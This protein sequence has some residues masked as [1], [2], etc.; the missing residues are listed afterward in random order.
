MTRIELSD[1]CKGWLAIGL[2]Y[3]GTAL[4]IAGFIGFTLYDYENTPK[5]PPPPPNFKPNI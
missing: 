5:L 3:G 2:L 1:N 4:V